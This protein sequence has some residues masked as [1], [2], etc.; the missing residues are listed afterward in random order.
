MKHNIDRVNIM[1]NA[2]KAKSCLDDIKYKLRIGAIEY[3]SAKE[4][5][6]PCLDSL[7]AGMEIIA[8]EH[9]FKHRKTSFSSYMR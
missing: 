9:G 4:M 8:K 1:N 6:S 5:A 3:S 7:N 2:R